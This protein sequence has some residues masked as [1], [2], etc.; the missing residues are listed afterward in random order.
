MLLSLMLLSLLSFPLLHHALQYFNVY[1][2]CIQC[3]FNVYS[4]CIQCVFNVYSMCIQC[5]FNVYSMY[6]QYTFNIHSMFSYVFIICLSGQW[7]TYSHTPNLE[8]LSHL[9]SFWFL[10]LFEYLL[11]MIHQIQDYLQ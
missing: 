11:Q 4:M 3:V 6:I 10:E 8:M 5:V 9:K 7:L 1:S 2:M